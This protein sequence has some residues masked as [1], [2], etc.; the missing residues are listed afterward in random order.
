[1]ENKKLIEWCLD[2][3]E[4]NN[5]A[6]N[7]EDTCIIDIINGYSGSCH[8]KEGKIITYQQIRDMFEEEEEEE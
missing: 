7:W 2:N 1:M 8:T 6:D 3:L 5:N 4:F